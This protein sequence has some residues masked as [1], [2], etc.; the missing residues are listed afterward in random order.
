MSSHISQS[1]K[2]QFR[3]ATNLLRGVCAFAILVWHYQHF[4]YIGTSG[5]D[6]NRPSQPFYFLFSSFYESGYLAVQIFWCISGLIM[7]HSYINRKNT[8]A[9]EFAVARFAR[10]YPIH[11]LTLLIVAVLQQISFRTLNTFQIY[12]SNDLFHFLLNLLFVQSWGFERG[13]SFNAP[14]WS[15][16]IEIIIYILFF[17]VISLLQRFRVWV[18]IAILIIYKLTVNVEFISQFR[19]CLVYFFF[20]VMIYFVAKYISQSVL[21]T[22]TFLI[23]S[24]EIAA[25]FAARYFDLINFNAGSNGYIWSTAFLVFVVAQIDHS[26]FARLFV[27]TRIIGDLSYSVFL[28]HIPIQILIKLVQAKYS[29]ANSIVYDKLFFIFYIALTYFVGY[30]SYQFFEQ[31]AQRI[32]RK[33]FAHNSTI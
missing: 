15:V 32:I 30:L 20:G 4:F 21:R 19:N 33:R 1:T 22:P 5:T 8:N 17:T 9:K 12:G 28:W 16:S 6:F 13:Y 29:S 31:P 18:P 3:E 7:A 11:I 23:L 27:K 10:L 25:Y 24:F 14:T 2:S 26:K